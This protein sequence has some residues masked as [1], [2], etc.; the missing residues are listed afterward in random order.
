VDINTLIGLYYALIYPF[1]TYGIIAW[2]NTYSSTLKPLYVL[3]K[4]A[5]RQYVM[6]FSKFR[7]HSSI[8]FKALNIIKLHDLVSYQIAIFMYRY[9]NR[10]L[11]RVFNNFFTEVSEARQYN[12][13]SAVKQSY[14]LQ[15]V[16]TNYGKF[17]IRFQVPMIWNAINE[18]VKTGSLSKFK[19]CLKE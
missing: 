5:L 19:L 18:Q 10:L 12:K 11:P 4:K 7:E 13:R 6:T 8:L 1:S 14:Y 17:N 3:Q 9:K 15:K 2:G 16:G